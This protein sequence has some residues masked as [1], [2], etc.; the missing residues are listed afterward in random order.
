[1]ERVHLAITDE[2]RACRV[3]TGGVNE[4]CGCMRSI[5][6]RFPS[7]IPVRSVFVRRSPP[8]P[9]KESD[10]AAAADLILIGDA[11]TAPGVVY[12]R[13]HLNFR[14]YQ[15]NTTGPLREKQQ[16]KEGRRHRGVF[17]IAFC[18]GHVESLRTN[19]LFAITESVTRRWNLD[20]QPHPGAWKF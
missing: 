19:N 8:K 2:E 17:N 14:E 10:V 13:S 9:V 18:D 15:L 11:S 6:R 1:M 5:S 16:A 3:P 4:D 7:R 20:N 12:A